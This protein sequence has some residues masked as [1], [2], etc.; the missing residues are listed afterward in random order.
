MSVAVR[1]VE[2]KRQFGF[3]DLNTEAFLVIDPD[4]AYWPQPG[5]RWL[6]WSSDGK[7]ISY[8]ETDR[9]GILRIN[10]IDTSNVLITEVNASLGDGADAGYWGRDSDRLIL[11]SGIQQ[12]NLFY[13]FNVQNNVLQ[14]IEVPIG[15]AY[16]TEPRWICE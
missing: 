12:K 4:Y 7:Y 9:E 16:A 15:D 8:L 1:Q 3:L 14:Q 5:V 11:D 10:V 13:V 6:S 2:E